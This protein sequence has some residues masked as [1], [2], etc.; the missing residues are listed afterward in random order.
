MNLS[1]HEMKV[2]DDYQDLRIINKIRCQ[3]HR[4]YPNN[5]FKDN[6]DYRSADLLNNFEQDIWDNIGDE[7]EDISGI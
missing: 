5:N 3:L 4:I 7:D 2:I 1:K 6:D